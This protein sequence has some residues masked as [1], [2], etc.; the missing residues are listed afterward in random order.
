MGKTVMGAVAES[1]PRAVIR[2]PAVEAPT[3]WCL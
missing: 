1:L 3:E 2:A